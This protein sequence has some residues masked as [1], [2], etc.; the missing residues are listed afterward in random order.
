MRCREVAE[1][2]R[3]LR[4]LLEQTEVQTLIFDKDRFSVA[5]AKKWAAAH[6]FKSGDTDEKENTIRLRQRDPG[7]YGSFR[8]IEFKPGV[9]AVVAK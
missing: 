8:T 6:G 7:E 2:L 5:S 4:R 1:S 9:Q 3:L